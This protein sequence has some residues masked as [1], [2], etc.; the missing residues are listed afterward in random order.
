MARG[1]CLANQKS[2]RPCPPFGP[3][4]GVLESVVASPNPNAE[5]RNPKEIRNPKSR[6]T[7]LAGGWPSQWLKLF[8]DFGLRVS[9]GFRFSAFGYQGCRSYSSSYRSDFRAALSDCIFF[10]I[11]I[12]QIARSE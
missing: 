7:S 10:T 9:L 4:R 1:Y 11:L 12:D 3:A 5:N 8:S 2:T 6:K